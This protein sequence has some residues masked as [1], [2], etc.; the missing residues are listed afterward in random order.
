MRWL[1]EIDKKGAR[2]FLDRVDE[3]D[4]VGIIFHDDLDGFASGMLV[5]D[6]LKQKNVND[7]EIFPQPI[8]NN[9]MKEISD[10]LKQKDKILI[11]DL[12][13][14]TFNKDLEILK[15]K[16]ILYIDHHKKDV[17]I[18][19]F[20]LEYRTISDI[21]VARSVYDLVGKDV[22]KEKEW[23]VNLALMADIGWRFE[24]N[25]R[26]VKPYLE[27]NNLTLE[28]FREKAYDIGYLLI[29][30]SSDLKKAFDI[31]D[32]VKSLD[33]FDK[34]E[35]YTKEVKQEVD[36]YVNDYEKNKEELGKINFY[37][38]EPKF[39]VKSNVTTIISFNNPRGFFI[40]GVGNGDEVRLSGR[41]QSGEFDVAEILKQAIEG[42]EGASAGG[43]KAAAGGSI[44][45]K[46]LEKFKENLKRIGEGL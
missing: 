6:F 13:P 14:N 41:C 34:I 46:D 29:Y 3:N 42:L 11:F 31:L 18:L 10:K 15:D 4:K 32:S 39:M 20:V 44:Q 27:K 19:D 24:D 23:I 28:Q 40:F 16:D 21:H 12:G 36:F 5:Y 35:K 7:L 30:F 33:D 43:H 38:F 25:L 26:L 22:S 2:E 8:Q 17:E 1:M 37:Y 9:W 45:K